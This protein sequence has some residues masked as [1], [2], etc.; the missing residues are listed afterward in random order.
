MY[1]QVIWD[2]VSGSFD[3]GDALEKFREQ[4]EE[5]TGVKH[6]VCVPMARVGIYLALKYYIKPGQRVI[7]SPY[8]IVDVINM[9]ICAGGRPVFADVDKETCNISVGEVARLL[10]DECGAVLVT[11]LHGLAC[12][13]TAIRELCHR[14]GVALIEDAAQSFGTKVDGTFVGAF[15][16]AGIYSFGAY[17]NMNSF[18]G[19]M[20]L[21]PDTQFFEWLRE[22]L[23]QYPK[24]SRMEMLKRV[25]NGAVMDVVTWRPA[26]CMF[27]FWLFRAGFLHGIDF[28]NKLTV[29][30]YK[31]VLRKTL[32]DHYRRLMIQTQ[33]RLLMQQLP[34]YQKDAEK[35][36]AL[37][38]VYLE[39][40]SGLKE[41]TLPPVRLDGSHSYTY[42]PIQTRNRLQLMRYCLANGADFVYGHYRNSAE[43]AIFSEFQG[44]CPNASDVSQSVIFLPVYP[45]Y[46]L[47]QAERNVALIREFFEVHSENN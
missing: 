44:D 29:V 7:L 12:D 35:R 16:N 20:V 25:L 43:L 46:P 1:Q 47:Q 5:M 21:T 39:G 6:A 22:T 4:I 31:P 26:F 13:I 41:V 19:G 8:T 18:V 33:G 32:P 3:S 36:F 30:D 28:I 45:T 11:H 24:L 9:V 2:L 17:K 14:R 10:S 37:A 38:R 27:T 42:F 23:S 15:G 34:N 40:L